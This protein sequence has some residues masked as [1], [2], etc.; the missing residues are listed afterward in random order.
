[1]GSG[2]VRRLNG[3]VR[4]LGFRVQVCSFIIYFSFLTSI[5][6]RFRVAFLGKNQFFEPSVVVVVVVLRNL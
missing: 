6:A 2:Q 3:G 5:A 1:M 4:P